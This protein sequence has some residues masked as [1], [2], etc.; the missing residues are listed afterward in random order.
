MT[1][2]HHQT[3]QTQEYY[4]CVRG[5]MWNTA[6]PIRLYSLNAGVKLAPGSL[7]CG[8]QSCTNN[9]MNRCSLLTCTF[10]QPS[11][12]SLD[13]IT[14]KSLF[15]NN[16]VRVRSENSKIE[17]EWNNLY[18]LC[19]VRYVIERIH[20]V[21]CFKALKKLKKDWIYCRNFQQAELGGFLFCSGKI[22]CRIC[23]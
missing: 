10:T 19:S 14:I 5:L 21:L 15:L 6:G 12:K 4:I 18:I 3:A 1:P 11:N 17:H 7:T 23:T 13:F 22:F 20:W 16:Q 9:Y 8:G 2:I